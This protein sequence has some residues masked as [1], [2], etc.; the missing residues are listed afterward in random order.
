MYH[1]QQ[2]ALKEMETY[3]KQVE[4]H[5][6]TEPT[7]KN[8]RSAGKPSFTPYQGPFEQRTHPN[9]KALTNLDELSHI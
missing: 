5:Q 2:E 9:G 8:E 4:G 6:H 7:Q 3:N 1:N